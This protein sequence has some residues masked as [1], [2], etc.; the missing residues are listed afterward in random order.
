MINS[1]DNSSDMCDK[2]IVRYEVRG[3]RRVGVGDEW[4]RERGG[5]GGGGGGKCGG[6]WG[7]GKCVRDR[8]EMDGNV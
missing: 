4:G 5:G 1:G 7:K 3:S 6:K 2:S 8:E